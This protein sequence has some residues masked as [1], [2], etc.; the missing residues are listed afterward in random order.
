VER[1]KRFLA[2]NHNEGQP[3]V[4]FYSLINFL[5]LFCRLNENIQGE[6]PYPHG[7]YVNCRVLEPIPSK[8]VVDVSLRKSRLEGDL[9]SDDSP[10]IGELAN[11]YVVSTN[12]KGCFLRLSRKIEGRAILKE[13]CDGFLPEPAASFPMGRLVVG[14]VKASRSQKKNHAPYSFPQVVDMDMRESVL[15]NSPDEVTFEDIKIGQKYKGTVSRIEEYGVFVRVQNSNVS[16]LVH[17]SECSDKYI[18]KLSD[19]YDPGDLVKI[20]VLK[21]DDGKKQVGFSMKASHF[22]N[23]ED[24]DDDSLNADSDT[25]EESM[26]IEMKQ[27]DNEDVDSDDENMVSKLAA[28]L[29]DGNENSGGGSIDSVSESGSDQ[30]SSDDD[31]S[32]HDSTDRKDAD[33][34]RTDL[35]Q[36]AGL[37]DTDVGFDWGGLQTG[38]KTVADETDED[39]NLSSDDDDEAPHKSSHK[40]R[41]KQAQRLREEQEIARR[42]IALADGSADINPETASDFERLLAANPDASE[43]WIKVRIG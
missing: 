30:G 38:L 40:S 20:L 8:P 35:R 28:R 13:L 43:I 33:E 31:S 16:G 15:V 9:E 36:K 29:H 41:R 21:K 10:E 18:K 34:A 1:F 2:L 11:A 4:Y 3:T 24:S 6:K 39:E 14:K 23:D 19:L 27:G 22:E 5:V 7:K 12:K 37:L 26:D 32:V 17:K 25:D 42:E